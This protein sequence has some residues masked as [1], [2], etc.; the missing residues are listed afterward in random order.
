MRG[1][2]LWRKLSHGFRQKERRADI[3]G[4]VAARGYER[5]LDFT[6]A[7][8]SGLH[9]EGTGAFV[10][11]R[12]NGVAYMALSERADLALAQKWVQA[13]GY[14]VSSH[15]M[16]CTCRRLCHCLCPAMKVCLLC[17]HCGQLAQ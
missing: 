8:A 13:M 2:V 12:I 16:P 9:L 3:Q 11:D 10:L 17:S 15:G 4:V 1:G 7:E 14:R 6:Q 5:T